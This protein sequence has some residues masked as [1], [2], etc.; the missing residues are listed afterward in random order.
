MANLGLALLLNLDQLISSTIM[1]IYRHIY[2]Q[3][4]F[5]WTYYFVHLYL[6]YVW[7]CCSCR[8]AVHINENFSYL[9]LIYFSQR[10][11]FTFSLFHNCPLLKLLN[12]RN[13]LTIIKCYVIYGIVNVAASKISFANFFFCG[14]LYLGLVHWLDR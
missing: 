4:T 2:F 6:I 11:I 8:K 13:Y 12:F 10:D 1:Q 9:L 5:H 7:L 3:T 14:L